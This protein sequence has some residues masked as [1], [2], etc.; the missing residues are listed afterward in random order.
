MGTNGRK[1]EARRI[2]H[3]K[4]RSHGGLVD[5][6]VPSRLP[7]DYTCIMIPALRITAEFLNDLY[8]RLNR[9]EYVHPDPI[10]AIYPFE[11]IED[12]E[13]AGMIAAALAFGRATSI[14]AAANSIVQALG[15]S[16]SKI[17]QESGYPKLSSLFRGFRYRWARAEDLCG[18]LAGIGRLQAEYGGLNACFLNCDANPEMRDRCGLQIARVSSFLLKLRQGS[19]DYNCLIP[20]P[21][22]AGAWK[23]VHLFLR[24]MIRCDA[25]DPG[26]WKGIEPSELIVPLDTHVHRFALEWGLTKR[27]QSGAAAALEITSSLK[28]FSPDDPVKYDFAIS[29]LGIRR[30]TPSE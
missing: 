20:F 11:W 10:E 17:L 30:M 16:P 23:R 27:K 6:G 19:K 4:T 13:A 24:W 5:C 1:K 21:E 26:G 8:F 7:E 2:C 12:R 14:V 29:R 22:P 25:I 3:A 15:P 18:L 28:N 9:R